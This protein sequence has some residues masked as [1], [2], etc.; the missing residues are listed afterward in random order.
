METSFF[1]LK[2]LCAIF[3][4]NVTRTS[5]QILFTDRSTEDM[6]PIVVSAPHVWRL[7]VNV[8]RRCRRLMWMSHILLPTHALCLMNTRNGLHVMLT[9]RSINCI[10][11]K[12][13]TR[14]P[15]S[16]TWFHGL[17]VFP[18]SPPFSEMKVFTELHDQHM[19]QL[20]FSFVK[21]CNWAS[22]S[23]SLGVSI[24]VDT[25]PPSPSASVRVACV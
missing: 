14:K 5:T 24:Y 22:G 3:N 10:S 25:P 21:T 4:G 1:Y 13:G 17:I 9:R 2:W 6:I 8:S 18:A 7:S 15:Q 11:S 19:L 20:N 23:I 12:G 16:E